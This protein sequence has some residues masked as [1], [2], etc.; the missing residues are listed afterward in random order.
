MFIHLL[1]AGLK[2][3]FRSPTGLENPARVQQFAHSSVGLGCIKFQVSFKT[4]S[5]SYKLGNLCD[6]VVLSRADVV[7]IIFSLI[8]HDINH[9]VGQVINVEHLR[10]R[11]RKV[12][13]EE[14]LRQW[15]KEG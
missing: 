15:I 2:V 4:H 10:E 3:D 8:P 13:R 14:E 11:R 7:Y 12:S 1:E 5:R 9:S 6:A